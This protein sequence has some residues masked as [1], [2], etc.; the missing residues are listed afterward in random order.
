MVPKVFADTNII[1]DFIEQR[2]F[3]IANVNRLFESAENN[4]ITILISESVMTN[5]LYVTALNT[6]IVQLLNIVSVLC[7]DE[8]SFKNAMNS[9]F[10]DKEDGILY[11]G[12][13]KGKADYFVTRNKK[14]FHN[15]S[16]K[17]LPVITPK[18][19]TARLGLQ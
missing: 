19:L 5:A 18:E 6:Q 2:A 16:L 10:R 7:I 8:D 13:L 11:Y 17:Q 1:I 3:D 14:D 9:S 15:Y 12:A 4:E